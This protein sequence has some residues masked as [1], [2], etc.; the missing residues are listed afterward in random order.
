MPS[1][2]DKI[3]VM[4][5]IARLNVGGPARHVV[6]LNSSLDNSHYQNL[7]VTGIEGVREGS[8]KDLV[9][10][11]KLEIEIIPELGREIALKNDLFVLWKLYHLMRRYRPHIVHTH[12]A[13]AGLVGRIAAKLAGVPIILHTFHGHVFHGYFSPAKT[14]LFIILEKFCAIL[15]DRIITISDRLK[16]EIAAY[17]VAPLDKIEIVPLGF[18]LSLFAAQTRH[19]GNFRASIGIPSEG[20]LIA[21]VGRLVPIKNIPLLLEAVAIARQSDPTIYLA[22]IGDGELR[23]HLESLAQELGIAE[24]VIFTGW[25]QDLPQIYAD[26]DAVIISSDNEGTPASLIEAMA[27]G[28][29]AIATHVGGVPDLVTPERGTIVK[30]KDPQHLACAILD[31]WQNPERTQHLAVNAREYVLKTYNS[32][33]LVR[34]IAQLYEK[35]MEFPH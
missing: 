28:C 9:E 31:L 29:P 16:E 1:S 17:G 5:I 26:L 19:S 15:S 4:R 3:R 21:A 30:P 7:L 14:K 24:A 34:D 6:L 8:M 11:H 35:L 25:R 18:D 33:R 12:T 23:S 22:L 10:T 2:S 27:T 32:Q 13:K 20:K